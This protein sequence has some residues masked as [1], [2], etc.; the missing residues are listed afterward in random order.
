LAAEA[1]SYESRGERAYNL[2]NFLRSKITI[3]QEL[4]KI[5]IFLDWSSIVAHPAALREVL[6]TV[7]PAVLGLGI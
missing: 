7:L 4:A 3:S 2:D 1:C 5:N 6:L